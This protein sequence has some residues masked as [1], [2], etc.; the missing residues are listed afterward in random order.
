MVRASDLLCSGRVK[1]AYKLVTSCSWFLP[2]EWRWKCP[3]DETGLAS[4]FLTRAVGECG[5]RVSAWRANPRLSTVLS[6]TSREEQSCFASTVPTPSP[7][8]T[9][10]TP[11]LSAPYTVTYDDDTTADVRSLS[12]ASPGFGTTTGAA[13]H[14]R[15]SRERK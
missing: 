12:R 1:E 11:P 13:T 3:R 10:T 14:S 9:H 4:R 2:R 7:T 5:G 15:D 8:P 6:S